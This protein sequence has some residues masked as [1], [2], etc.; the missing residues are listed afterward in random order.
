[1]RTR[2]SGQPGL[3][4]RG[5]LAHGTHAMS[6]SWQM[7]DERKCPEFTTECRRAGQTSLIRSLTALGYPTSCGPLMGLVGT[8]MPA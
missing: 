6:V 8:V 7:L 1:M 2:T 3:V 5:R 4:R